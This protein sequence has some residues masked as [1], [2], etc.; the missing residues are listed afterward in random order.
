LINT[1]ESVFWLEGKFIAVFLIPCSVSDGVLPYSLRI[2][3]R[4]DDD[5]ECGRQLVVKEKTVGCWGGKLNFKWKFVLF[6]F[7]TD[8][9]KTF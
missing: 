3:E 7:L 6:N 5:D 1:P 2:W 4:H 9:I 8:F